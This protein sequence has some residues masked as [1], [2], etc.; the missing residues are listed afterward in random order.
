MVGV[1]GAGSAA[2]L[3]P[4]REMAAAQSAA[5]TGPDQVVAEVKRQLKEALTGLENGSGESARHAAS[6]A[7]VWAAQ[8]ATKASDNELRALAQ[9]A[10]RRRGRAAVV[11]APIN[12]R[13]MNTHFRALGLSDA[14][15]SALDVHGPIDVQA[16]EVALDRVLKGGVKPVVDRAV[17]LL[18]VAG[19]RL[20]AR[21]GVRPIAA[22]AA[23][24]DF[25][26]DLCNGSGWF[27]TEMEVACALAALAAI[28]PAMAVFIEVCAFFA[29]LWVVM[30]S[31]CQAC[32]M[33]LG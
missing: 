13:E 19:E 33:I 2:L 12:H 8:I 15:I 3:L 31:A 17:A 30:I 16:R 22:A 4:P 10:V 32:R 23:R 26:D 7:R 11:E 9:R 25:C 6:L 29:G 18:Q 14:Q 21:G 28:I 5:G 24:N 1:V 20:E 27:K